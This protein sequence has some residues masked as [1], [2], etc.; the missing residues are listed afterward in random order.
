MSNTLIPY[1][2]DDEDILTAGKLLLA[3]SATC[4]AA[5]TPTRYPPPQRQPFDAI[6]LDMNFSPVRAAAGLPVAQRILEL[7]PDAE[8]MITAHGSMDLAVEAMKLGAT[9]FV[10]KP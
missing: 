7:D 5:T 1:R 8:I 6:L 4:M 9:D 3:S 10:A 2:D